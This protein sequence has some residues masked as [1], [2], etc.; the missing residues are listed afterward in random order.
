M[1]R[2]FFSF[3]ICFCFSHIVRPQN[4]PRQ[5]FICQRTY[6]NLFKRFSLYLHWHFKRKYCWC[7]ITQNQTDTI[8]DVFIYVQCTHKII[9]FFFFCF[10]L[11]RPIIVYSFSSISKIPNVGHQ[12]ITGR[13]AFDAIKIKCVCV[14]WPKSKIVNKLLKLELK[15]QNA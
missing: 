10:E 5:I 13:L 12:L 6:F 4:S 3:F 2:D 8:L 7:C 15:D 1:I 14:P 11:S 9:I